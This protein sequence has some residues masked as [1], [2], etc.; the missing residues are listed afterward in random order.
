MSS[1]QSAVLDVVGDVADLLHPVL[2]LF[3][4]GVAVVEAA[5]E[6]VHA[7]QLVIDVLDVI[8]DALDQCVLLG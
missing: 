3:A 1:T 8:A 2:G 4:P 6:G 7:G 5:Q